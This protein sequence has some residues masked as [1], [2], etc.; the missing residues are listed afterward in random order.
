MTPPTRAERRR[1]G[2][3]VSADRLLAARRPRRPSPTEPQLPRSGTQTFSARVAQPDLPVSG[4]N[5]GAKRRPIP[6]PVEHPF[7]FADLTT[8]R[9]PRENN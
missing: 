1:C 7:A 2:P 4:D 9:Q 6:E 3:E 5:H 8:N